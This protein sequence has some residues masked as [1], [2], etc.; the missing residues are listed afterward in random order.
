MKHGVIMVFSLILALCL[1]S[2]VSANENMT[3]VCEDTLIYEE[4]IQIDSIE[5]QKN[6]YDSGI[7]E[8]EIIYSPDTENEYNLSEITCSID[9]MI[10]MNIKNEYLEINT[11]N[12][13]VE[14]FKLTKINDKTGKM[15]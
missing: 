12:I 9:D 13:D 3:D 7:S 6:D 15:F 10:N 4:N 2:V 8:D 1:I 5:I 14:I 11:D